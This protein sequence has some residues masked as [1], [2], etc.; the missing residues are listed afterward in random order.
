MSV[1]NVITEIIE[2]EGGS[3]MTND[4]T[5]RGGRTQYGIAERSNPEAWKDGKVT[6]QEAREIYLQKYVVGPGFHRIPPS[7]NKSQALLVDWGVNS[8]PAIAIKCLQKALDVEDDGVFGPQ[9]LAALITRDVKL[10]N[11]T[12]VIAR[13]Q[14]VGRIVSKNPNQI[15]FLSGWLNR[16]LGF[17]N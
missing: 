14:M 11:T 9:T 2:R 16:A 7:H 13:V 4:P 3:K 10:I 12:L 17:L 6:E 5:D 8:G 1:D 15:K